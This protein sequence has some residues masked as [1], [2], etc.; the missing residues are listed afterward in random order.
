VDA[1]T[2]HKTLNLFATVN[3]KLFHKDQIERIEKSNIEIE[4]KER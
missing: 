3:D 4:L 2:E 1:I